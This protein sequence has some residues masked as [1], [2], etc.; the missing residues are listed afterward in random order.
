MS[1]HVLETKTIIQKPLSEVFDFFSKAENLNRITPKELEFKIITPLPI[2][3]YAGTLIDYK[4][5]LN[6]IP[7]S[8]R[9]EI[10]TWDPPHKFVDQQLKGPYAKWH[11]T[12]EFKDL[13]DGCTEMIDRVV[14]KSPGWIF[15]PIIHNLFVKKRVEA[16]FKHREKTLLEIFE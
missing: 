9:T 2:K 11:H 16:I 5:K 14:Y 8:W 1:E 4:I 13:G 12:H 6:G 7:F 15:E 10:C 3:M